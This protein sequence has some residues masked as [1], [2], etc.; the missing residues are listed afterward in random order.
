MKAVLPALAR[1]LLEPALP[2]DLDVAWF[3]TPDDAA[4]MI[5]D[6]DIAWTDMSPVTPIAAALRGARDRA[7]TRPPLARVRHRLGGRRR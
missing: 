6:A 3:R 7:R 2:A 4:A 5:A 1:P